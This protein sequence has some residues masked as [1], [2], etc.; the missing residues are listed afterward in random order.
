MN[1]YEPKARL[2][3]KRRA[4]VNKSHRFL[5]LFCETSEYAVNKVELYR[6]LFL[7]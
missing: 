7:S 3:G 2:G 4:V 1:V 5:V 6:T